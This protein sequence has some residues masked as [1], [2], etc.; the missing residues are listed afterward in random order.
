MDGT[1]RKGVKIY[2]MEQKIFA[3][4]VAL[5]DVYKDE[6]DRE[7]N[8]I[9]PIEFPEN[10]DMTEDIYCMLRAIQMI[11]MI[12]TGDNDMDVLDVI[13]MMNRL[14]FQYAEKAS[15]NEKD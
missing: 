5:M 1:D 4:M 14:A 10:G 2:N 15:D 8:D 13:A 3:F 7:L 12:I 6:D 11:I 9:S